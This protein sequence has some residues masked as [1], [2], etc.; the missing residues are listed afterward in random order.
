MGS[1]HRLYDT[2][3][4]AG[5]R[6]VDF[7]GW[8]MPVNY[9]SQIE[10]HHAVRRDA[11]MFDVSHMLIADV[12]GARARDYLRYLLANDVAK[13][14][15]PGKALY[16]CMLNERGGVV[17]DLIVYFVNEIWFRVVVN[18]GTRDKDTAW[19]KRHAGPFQVDVRPRTDLA[20]IAVQGPNA[21][22]KAATLLGERA[23]CGARAQAFLR[24]RARAVLRRPHRLHRRGRLG[25]HAAGR[26]CAGV[27]GQRSRPPALPSAVSVRATRCDWK[28]A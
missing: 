3:V 18:A 19:L 7:G 24:P 10:E 13:L 23:G 25:N 16:S 14:K 11:G 27:L 22:A 26:R 12:T 17:D 28:P 21:R 8:D 2:H 9:G 6:M 5:A 15:D 4:A 1:R 20:M